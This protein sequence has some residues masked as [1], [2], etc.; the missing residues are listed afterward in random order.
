[1]RE[2]WSTASL[3]PEN[4]ERIKREFIEDALLLAESFAMHARRDI[5]RGI[6][7]RLTWLREMSSGSVSRLGT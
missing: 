5:E 7:K 2:G 6:R 1:M 4:S 3:V